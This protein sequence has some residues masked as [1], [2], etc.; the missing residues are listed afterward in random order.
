MSSFKEIE[1]GDNTVWGSN[2]M[3]Y[4]MNSYFFNYDLGPKTIYDRFANLEGNP[5]SLT[6]NLKQPTFN[7]KYFCEDVCLKAADQNNQAGQ[8]NDRPDLLDDDGIPTVMCC[9]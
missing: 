6:H 8:W 4:V 2:I 9:I 1:P 3:K 7:E 5:I